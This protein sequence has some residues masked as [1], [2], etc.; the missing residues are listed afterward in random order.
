MNIEIEVKR[1]HLYMSIN[2]RW[3]GL[4]DLYVRWPIVGERLQII[5]GHKYLWG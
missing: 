5:A 1:I 4:K 3:T 2:T